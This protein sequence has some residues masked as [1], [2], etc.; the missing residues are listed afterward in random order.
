MATVVSQNF[1]HSPF[2]PLKSNFDSFLSL[3]HPRPI[4]EHGSDHLTSPL[5]NSQCHPIAILP[6]NRNIAASIISND[7][8]V[9]GKWGKDNLVSF[10]QSK[11][12][13]AVI[14]RTRNLE[15]RPILMNGDKLDTSSSFTQLC[16]PLSSHLTWK[17][18]SIPL[19]K[20]QLRSS[21]S[22]PDVSL[23]FSPKSV[24]L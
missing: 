13:Q 21:V 20:M 5:Q 3:L 6:V 23:V 11:T 19:L 16:L 15:F 9:I 14:S 2:L 17:I 1:F 10:S 22:S 24:L 12:T 18:T 7:L 4:F 8:T